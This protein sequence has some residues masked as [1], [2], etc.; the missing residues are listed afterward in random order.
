MA[1]SPKPK[2]ATLEFMK[3][4]QEDNRKIVSVSPLKNEKSNEMQMIKIDEGP[5]P[6][7]KADELIPDLGVKEENKDNALFKKISIKG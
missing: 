6:E 1:E 4:E 7:T 5:R 3:Y 2:D